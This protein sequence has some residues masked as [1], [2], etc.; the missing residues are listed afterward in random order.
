MIRK[1]SVG[2]TISYINM[3]VNMITGLVLSSF[4]LR[5]LGDTEYGLYQTIASFS[6]YLV[7]LEFGT[8]TVMTRN[9]SVCLNNTEPEKRQEQVNRNYSTIWIISLVLSVVIIAVSFVFYLNLGNIYANSMNASQIKYGKNIF[10]FLIVYI[11]VNVYDDTAFRAKIIAC[12][13]I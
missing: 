10:L 6:T 5:T 2:I 3:V 13:A 12:L 1:R 9:V 8:G 11:I 4:L 7:L